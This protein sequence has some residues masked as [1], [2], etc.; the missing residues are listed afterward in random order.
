V[1]DVDCELMLRQR[2]LA[3]EP[4][5]NA[6]GVERARLVAAQAA[7]DGR[8]G[9]VERAASIPLRLD[10]ARGALPARWYSPLL[11]RPTG[12]MLVYF[13]GG[14][15]VTGD[16][17][18]HDDVC[19]ELAH[20]SG[21]GVLSVEYRLAPEHPFPAQVDDARAAFASARGLA[22]MLGCDPLR[23]GVAG[24]SA[25][26]NL[27]ATVAGAA[28]D[29]IRPAC[30]LLI[31]PWL[32]MSLQERS[33]A[34]FGEGFGLLKEELDW[35][36]ELWLGGAVDA[37]EPSASPSKRE[38]L[39]DASPA[40]VVVAGF[41]PLRDEAERYAQRLQRAGVPVT[42]QR[43]P[44]LVHGFVEFLGLSRAARHAVTDMGTAVRGL[45][46]RSRPDEVALIAA[47]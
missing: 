25:G 26:G 42:V 27:A 44:G 17:D 20:A 41:D 3:G 47:E 21:A 11:M 33:V 4:S 23:V 18:T 22:G 31:Y 15:F 46:D 37:A 29:G 9:R 5:L 12:A 7:H 32:D 16:L 1:L 13:H 2:L 34:T 35:F 10:G 24:D 43:H 14:G 19:R 6:C 45:L 8:A 36:R 39:G 40:H 30:Q 28:T 38:D